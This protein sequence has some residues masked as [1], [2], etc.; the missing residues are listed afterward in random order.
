MLAGYTFKGMN[1]E[2]RVN[3]TFV[4]HGEM[5]VVKNKVIGQALTEDKDGESILALVLKKEAYHV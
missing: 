4:E 3:L 2:L 1:E 5:R